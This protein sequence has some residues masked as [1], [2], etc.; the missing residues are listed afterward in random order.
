[1]NI[2][3]ILSQFEVTEAENYA[4]TIADELIERGNKVFIISD[5]LT[6][7]TKAQY[8][9]L[10]F[11][12]K[13]LLNRITH[14]KALYKF[15]KENNIHI[16]HAYSRAFSWS[17]EIVCKLAK[18][19][20]LELKDIEKYSNLSFEDKSFL[21]DK[22]YEKAN[23]KTVVDKIE[24]KYFD[25]YVNK[26]KYDIPV[27][28]YHR[29]VEKKEKNC[30]HKTYLLK[31]TFYKHMKYLKENNFVPITF[32]DLEKIGW[33]NRFDKKYILITL[34]DGYQ[35]NYDHAFPIFKEFNF[36]ATIFLMAGTTYNEWDVK[37]SNELV[38][39]LM[40]TE[41]IKEMQDY[42]I[43]FG[44]HTFNHPEI[45]TLTNEEIYHQV[46]ECKKVLEDKIGK[47]IIAFAYPYG[48]WTE[49]AK[50]VARKFYT[51]A[52]ATDS[53]EVNFSS[54][55]YQI[56][57]IGIVPKT[58]LF[59]FKKN[60]NGSYSFVKIKKEIRRAKGKKRKEKLKNIKNNFIKK[61]WLAKI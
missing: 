55:L 24:K 46:G 2:L 14:I 35:S 43:E 19:P 39:P 32:K 29:I 57:R 40:T 59:R 33:R 9:K 10:E 26:K 47:E 6:K 7:K 56:R 58:N 60:V 54:D 5:T 51:Y 53:G 37:N 27:V 23:L 15:I 45:D 48:I 18:I 16:V 34:D 31:K 3:M 12:K 44:A 25:L 38:F 4:T 11:N 1:M 61:F 28:M 17:Y 13:S 20:L 50:E 21:E 22:L 8:F 52:V 42:G 49:Y 41:M 30:V 36:K